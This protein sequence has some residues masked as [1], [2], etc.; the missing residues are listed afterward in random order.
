MIDFFGRAK[1]EV[2]ARIILGEIASAAV[3][4]IG[5]CD[6]AGYEFHS[7]TN[8]HAIALAA[9]QVEADPI[10]AWYAVIFQNHGSAVE[11]TDDYVHIA[12]V[13]KIA[14]SQTA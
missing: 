12:I 14:Y 8:R 9:R 10:A 5:L 1:A 11:V 6:T 13:E 3:H 7:R 2:Q 4:L